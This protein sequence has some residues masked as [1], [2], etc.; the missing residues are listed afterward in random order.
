MLI[1]AFHATFEDRIIAFDSVGM[2]DTA[3]IFIGLVADAFMAREMFTE[4]EIMAAF[5]GHYRG[6]FRNIGLDDR[7]Y[8]GRASSL[9][10]GT[11]EPAWSCDQREIELHFCG[12][13]RTA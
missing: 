8:I 2:D 4:R 12:R 11:S 3:N 10:H 7:D 1:D 9:R 5:V 13:G 6:F